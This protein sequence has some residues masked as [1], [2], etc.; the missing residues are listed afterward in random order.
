MRQPERKRQTQ[1]QK[2]EYK[3]CN[4]N[5]KRNKNEAL[6]SI[7]CVCSMDL[8]RQLKFIKKTQQN[9]RNNKICLMSE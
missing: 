5:N 2:M 3:F 9:E 8:N 6:Q 1:R 4:D 7:A